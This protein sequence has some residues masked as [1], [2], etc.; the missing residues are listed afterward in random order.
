[1]VFHY[2]ILKSW[3]CVL[4]ETLYHY[5]D[6]FQWCFPK[7]LEKSFINR[8]HKPG[9]KNYVRNYHLISKLLWMLQS[10]WLFTKTFYTNQFITLSK[11]LINSLKHNYQMDYTDLQKSFKKVIH[12]LLFYKLKTFGMNRNFLNWLNSYKL[13]CKFFFNFSRV[14]GI[15]RC[16]IGLTFKSTVLTNIHKWSTLIFLF[17]Y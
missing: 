4:V 9:D 3:S 8:V 15:F 16:S 17:S 10:S 6:S 5:L 14:P 2:N 7:L 11:D 13:S 1:M 12:T